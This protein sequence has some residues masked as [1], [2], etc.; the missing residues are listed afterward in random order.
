MNERIL[1]C[2]VCPRGCALTITLDGGK[3]EKIEGNACPRGI[4][5]ATAECTAPRRTVTTTVRCK[6]GRVLPV[7]TDKTVP[8]EKMFEVMAEINSAVAEDDA[9]IGDIIIANVCG[10]DANV[11]A[12][13]NR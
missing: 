6:S 13:A 8:K 12:T 2:I 4:D 1:T 7:K 11:V 3:I 9:K 5:Y 10:T